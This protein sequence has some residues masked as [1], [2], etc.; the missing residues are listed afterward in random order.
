MRSH[1]GRLCR[2]AVREC[3]GKGNVRAS[4]SVPLAI[5]RYYRLVLQ[6]VQNPARGALVGAGARP[7]AYTQDPKRIVSKHPLGL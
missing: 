7:S 1:H 2:F 6:T 5:P 3:G 4:D